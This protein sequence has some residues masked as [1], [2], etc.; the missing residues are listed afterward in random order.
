MKLIIRLISNVFAVWVATRLE[1]GFIIQGDW[2]ALVFAG[3]VLGLLNISLKPV[4][5][6]L[7][8]PL[9]LLT[10]GLFNL[11]INGLMLWVMDYL[12]LSVNIVN[13]SALVWATLIV[14][15]V[16]VLTTGSLIR[17]SKPEPKLWLINTYRSPRS[18]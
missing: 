2:K 14:W 5:K 3:L 7:T 11:V 18:S 8:F 6:T 10:L 12:L 13:L 1:P 17:L 15:L 9:I 16:N 4:I